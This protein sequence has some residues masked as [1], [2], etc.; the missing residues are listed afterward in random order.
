MCSLGICTLISCRCFWKCASLLI[1]CNKTALMVLYKLT[2]P[3]VSVVDPLLGCGCSGRWLHWM[4]VSAGGLI[5]ISRSFNGDVYFLRVCFIIWSKTK[6]PFWA[7]K[8]LVFGRWRR[9]IVTLACG[10]EPHFATLYRTF[11]QA[12]SVD[13]PNL[14]DIVLHFL[15]ENKNK[16]MGLQINRYLINLLQGQKK[17]ARILFAQ[18]LYIHTHDNYFLQRHNTAGRLGSPYKKLILSGGLLSSPFIPCTNIVFI[19]IGER[20]FLE[21]FKRLCSAVISIKK[22]QYSQIPNK[23]HIKHLLKVAKEHRFSGMLVATKIP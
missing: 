17:W 12:S 7:A 1:K 18:N 21:D 22:D 9:G 14:E 16:I 15:E 20:T 8:C 4:V 11:S 5:S 3:F 2:F 10:P 19:E 23:S 6:L 13:S